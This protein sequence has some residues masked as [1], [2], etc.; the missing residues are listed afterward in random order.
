MTVVFDNYEHREGLETSWGFACMVRGAQKTILFDT[1]GDGPILLDN[2]MKLSIDTREVDVVVLSHA[3][4]DHTGGLGAFIR[5]NPDVTV[6]MP[7]S[8]PGRFASEV[9]ACVTEVVEVREPLEICDSVHST[10]EMGT[11]IIEQSL[12]LSTD[13]GLV[14]IT[15]CA[16]PGI[17]DIL[18]MIM[19]RFD[20][21][22]VL[23]VMGGF[24]LRSEPRPDRIVERFRELGVQRVGPCH[25]SGQEIRE[26]FAARYG[27]DYIEVGVGASI[28]LRD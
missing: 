18:E 16:H 22:E 13:R 9:T 20:Q 8:F 10:G 28:T 2:M 7:Q 14:L 24:H 23:L 15:G 6:F 25:C 19:S 1:G 3:H 12:V 5:L 11:A 26:S 4:P 17:A 21:D 27:P